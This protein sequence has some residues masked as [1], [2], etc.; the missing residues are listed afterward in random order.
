MLPAAWGKDM[1]PQNA[2]PLSE[3]IKAA[4]Q[5]QDFR[6]VTEIEFDDGVYEVEYYTQDGAKK[7]VRIDPV[8][9]AEK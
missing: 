3:I 8:S 4:E 7:E 5:R 6:A 9:G 2:K 1:P